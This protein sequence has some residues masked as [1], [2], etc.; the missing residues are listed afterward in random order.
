M[1]Y[2]IIKVVTGKYLLPDTT[3]LFYRSINQFPSRL[4][5]EEIMS[6]PESLIEDW[7]Y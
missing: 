1:G 2:K 4:S 7:T 5:R 6:Q 3:F